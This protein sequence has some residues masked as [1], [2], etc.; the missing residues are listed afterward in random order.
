ME[1]PALTDN[2]QRQTKHVDWHVMI[3]LTQ[4]SLEREFAFIQ[5][6]L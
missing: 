6:R 5:K 4:F 3:K 2:E 1:C